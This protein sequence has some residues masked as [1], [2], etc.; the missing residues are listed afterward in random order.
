MMRTRPQFVSLTRGTAV[1]AAHRWQQ[2]YLSASGED[3]RDRVLN[4]RGREP[5]TAG[6]IYDQLLA[7]GDCAT[8]EQVAEVIGNKSWSFV[9]CD[10]CS[11]E[12]EA[13]VRLG[14]AYDTSARNYCRVCI[15]EAVDLFGGNNGKEANEGSAS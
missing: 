10:S 15:W 6:K 11:D 1:G 7:L 4:V 14:D 5:T 12:V 9:R 8:S 3:W 13:T 2:Q